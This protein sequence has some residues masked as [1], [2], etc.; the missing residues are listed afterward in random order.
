LRFSPAMKSLSGPAWLELLAQDCGVEDPVQRERRKLFILLRLAAGGG[1][2]LLAPLY[3]LLVG[4]PTSQHL[5]LFVLCLT[6]FV[7][8]GV[9]KRT[10]DLSFAQNVSICGWS[11]LAIGVGLSATA[12]APV[13]AMLLTVA[14]IEAALTLE[15]I[16]VGAAACAGFVLVAIYAGLPIFGDRALFPGR[17]EVAL[18][19]GPAVLRY[20]NRFLTAAGAPT[21]HPASPSAREAALFLAASALNGRCG[22]AQIS[23]ADAYLARP[24]RCPRRTL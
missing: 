12:F 18:A 1:A 15:T 14:L 10:G 16:V 8:I 24:R 9:L 5:S 4:L 6:P 23:P 11:A 13:A 7:S 17:P 2:L 22:H 20:G 19:L 21:V 3:L